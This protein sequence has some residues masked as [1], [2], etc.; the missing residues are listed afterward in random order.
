MAIFRPGP[1]IAAISGNV[2]GLNFAQTRSG[3]IIR[4]K[5]TRTN[6]KT[7]RQ[8][9]RRARFSQV[10]KDWAVATDLTR[11]QWRAAA[12]SIKRTNRLGLPSTLTGFQLFVM[13]SLTNPVSDHTNFP[14][15][16]HL[17]A[18]PQPTS[19]VL[20]ASAAGQINLAWNVT[21]VPALIFCYIFGMRT[22]STRPRTFF[23]TWRYFAT[24]AGPPGAFNINLN[25]FWD[26]I[27]AHPL[28]GEVIAVKLRARNI[29]YLPSA[30]VQATAVTAA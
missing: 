12:A 21:D 20:T 28:E 22:L 23:N 29:T 15:P 14:V 2:G 17:T 3:P 1:L 26:P 4:R 25:A 13:N 10:Q 18:T 7:N 24:D 27:F 11:D 8:L 6:K 16:P 30:F 5:T 9:N 19:V